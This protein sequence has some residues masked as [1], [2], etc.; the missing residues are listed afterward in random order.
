[1][2]LNTFKL[3]QYIMKVYQFV[4][5]FKKMVTRKAIEIL[6]GRNKHKIPGAYYQ[7]E[8]INISLSMLNNIIQNNMEE[9]KEASEYVRSYIQ[10]FKDVFENHGSRYK[11]PLFI[12]T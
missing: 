7:E 5:K 9:A 3:T 12:L 10:L 11:K 1:M 6:Q 8:L 2:L 4:N